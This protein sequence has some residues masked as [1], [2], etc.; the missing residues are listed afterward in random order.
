MRKKDKI[1]EE[2]ILDPADAPTSRQTN[3]KL[4]LEVFLDIRRLLTEFKPANPEAVK[5]IELKQTN[6]RKHE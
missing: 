2:F 4:F 6:D 3:A 5:E 1:L